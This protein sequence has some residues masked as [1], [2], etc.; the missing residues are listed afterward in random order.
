MI[1]PRGRTLVGICLVVAALLAGAAIVGGLVQLHDRL[2]RQSPTLTTLFWLA[3]IVPIV[4]G[5]AY[6][7]WRYAAAKP[8]P[9]RVP[10]DES[11]AVEVQLEAIE[12][13]IARIENPTARA[14]LERELARIRPGGRKEL[15]VVIF[16]TGSAGKTSL[17]NA[18]LGRQAGRTEAVIG[19]T[20]ETHEHL[21]AHHGQGFVYLADTP[22]L[23]EIGTAGEAREREARDLAVRA[24][25]LVFVVDHDLVRAEFETLAALARHGKRSIVFFNK[26][27]RFTEHDR[28]S[29]LAKLRERLKGVIAPDDILA[30]A[31]APRPLTVKRM[32]AD[33][34]VETRAEPQ[35]PAI[36]P[37]RVRM[38]AILAAEG[39]SLHAGNLLLRAHLL[40]RKAQDALAAERDARAQ[41]VIEKFQW[42]TAATVFANPF[43]AVELVAGGAVQLQM[44]SEIA[45]VY[46]VELS[47][48]HVR[49]IASRM[50][51]TLV[52]LGLLE[53]ASS[54]I[55]GIFKS[56]LV[57]YAAG[58]AVQ[59]VSLAYLTHVSGEAF[60][61][62]FRRGQS[63]GDGG[64]QAELI[65][66]FDLTSRV[67][68][69][70]E[71]ARQAMRKA[72]ER[73]LK[74]SPKP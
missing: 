46:D 55:A 26:T 28:D 59:A 43:P 6:L 45:A 25:L 40:A 74:A 57:G 10:A 41:A 60:A 9:P 71:F 53:T 64:I 37:L 18:L 44:V 1:R 34:I 5:S 12:K 17:V 63:W 27:D 7:L 39:E 30:G 22:G 20:Q 62:Y 72:S 51:Q 52:K 67:D 2:E 69:L 73:M 48:A 56:S 33:G 58:G 47:A 13:V 24:D 19:T 29:I 8:P 49:A 38:D 32:R 70:Q 15:K 23:A 61:T 14:E 65:R 35:T 11:G 3:L 4:G 54:L 16:G 66:Q 31:A 36:D 50:I 42:I 21:H 68:F